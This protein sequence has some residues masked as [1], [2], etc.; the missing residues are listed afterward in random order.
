MHFAGRMGQISIDV[1]PQQTGLSRNMDV[2]SA[3][4]NAEGAANT[5][6]R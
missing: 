1:L 6:P 2:P 4:P 5:G 3:P